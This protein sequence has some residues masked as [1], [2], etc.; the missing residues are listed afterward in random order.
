VAKKPPASEEVPHVDALLRL[1]SVIAIVA[2]KDIPPEDAA[3]RL[4]KLGF[5]PREIAGVLGVN[6]NYVHVIKNRLKK[7]TSKNRRA[8]S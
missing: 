4:D 1:A 3:I 8:K 6:D 7:D 5:S 2:M